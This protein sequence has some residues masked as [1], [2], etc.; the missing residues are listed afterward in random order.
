MFIGDRSGTI[1]RVRA[2]GQATM[3]ATLP[4]SVA[5]FHLTM[6]PD[7]A[8]YVT[9]PTLTSRDPVYRVHL[10]GQVETAWTGFGR[11]QG[12]TF[13]PDGMLYVI[14]ALAGGSGL[15]RLTPGRD[16][17]L[18]IAGEGLIGVAFEPSGTVVVASNERVWRLNRA[19]A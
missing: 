7:R 18:V 11:P 12:L 3:M 14:E 2:N 16:P 5:A 10:D 13:G 15:Y 17:E 6:G 19:W 9:A 4:Q 8:L 1:F